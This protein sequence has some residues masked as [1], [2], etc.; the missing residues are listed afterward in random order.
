LHPIPD[1]LQDAFWGGGGWNCGGTEK[2][3][4]RSWA[5]PKIKALKKLRTDGTS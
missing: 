4:L 3:L 1:H 2:P 5:K